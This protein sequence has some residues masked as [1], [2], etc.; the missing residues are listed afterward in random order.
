MKKFLQI[1]LCLVLV[2]SFA[3]MCSAFAITYGGDNPKSIRVGDDPGV[4]FGVDV[5]V[6]D[7]S[8]LDWRMNVTSDVPDTN[9][10]PGVRLDETG[11]L[12]GNATTVGTYEILVSVF[13]EGT[14]DS[15]TYNFTLI[16]RDA[17]NDDGGDSGGCNSGLGIFAL[18]VLFSKK[19]LYHKKA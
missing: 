4:K 1:S 16:V 11:K 5:A 12:T 7:D 3:S 9:T 19:F 14:N 13:R 8:E 15:A 17:W 10:I 6:D 2:L 18:A